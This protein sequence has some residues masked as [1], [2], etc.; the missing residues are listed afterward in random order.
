MPALDKNR[1]AVVKFA[2]DTKFNKLDAPRPID[3]PDCKSADDMIEML[4]AARNLIAVRRFAEL[5]KPIDPFAAISFAPACKDA[6]EV[7][8]KPGVAANEMFVVKAPDVV[9]FALGVAA[10]CIAVFNPPDATRLPIAA[11]AQLICVEMLADADKLIVPLA[12]KPL[13][14]ASSPAVA[15]KLANALEARLMLVVN[16]PK[17][18]KLKLLLAD[19][20]MP[21][22]KLAELESETFDDEDI[23]GSPATSNNDDVT[24]NKFLSSSREIGNNSDSSALYPV[25]FLVILCLPVKSENSAS[26][27]VFNHAWNERR[28]HQGSFSNS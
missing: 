7:R 11:D 17:A 18:F 6:A 21:V 13:L 10:N 24:T 1:I 5:V 8:L 9:K 16:A 26:F 22:D 15:I 19:K 20:L 4:G 23:L 25:P 3:E 27:A 2:F 12:D 14:P 28:C